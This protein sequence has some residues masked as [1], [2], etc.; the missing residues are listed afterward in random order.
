MMQRKRVGAGIRI[1]KTATCAIPFFGLSLNDDFKAAGFT[2]HD[3]F[4]ILHFLKDGGPA[5]AAGYRRFCR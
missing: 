5:D 4:S 2:V 1:T 3:I